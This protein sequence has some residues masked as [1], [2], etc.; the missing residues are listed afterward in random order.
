M[1]SDPILPGIADR[2]GDRLVVGPDGPGGTETAVVEATGLHPALEALRDEHGFALA[3]DLTVVDRHP[4]EPRFEVVYHLASVD[5]PRRVRLVVRLPGDDP[6]VPSCQDLWPG[7]GWHEREAWDLYGV[8][9]EGHPD[10]RRI[11]L[12]G[13]FEGH[14]L[15]KD[16]PKTKRQP[17]LPISDPG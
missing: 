10:L 8:R 6:V 7:M 12:Y 4:A 2:L 9:F 1:S 17:R 11:L 16:Y 15:R 14:P 3:L 5:P 13:E